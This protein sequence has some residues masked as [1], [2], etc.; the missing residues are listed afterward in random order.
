MFL[1]TWWAGHGGQ[2]RQPPIH[3]ARLSGQGK[4]AT[5]IGQTDEVILRGS[6]GDRF[7]AT[8]RLSLSTS[9]VDRFYSQ[10]IMAAICGL[11][12]GQALW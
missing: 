8:S 10:G 6:A 9:S 4:A 5:G 7:F 12:V 2:G 11:S 1:A 3:A